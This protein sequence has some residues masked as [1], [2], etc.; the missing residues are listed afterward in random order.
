MGYI[1]YDAAMQAQIDQARGR[2]KRLDRIVGGIAVLT[3]TIV[4]SRL[5]RFRAT[6]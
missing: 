1:H 2:R 3:A 6:N 5:K 4:L